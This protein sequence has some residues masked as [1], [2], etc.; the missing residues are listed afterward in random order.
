MHAVGGGANARTRSA[1][2]VG[3]HPLAAHRGVACRCWERARAR[4][5]MAMCTPATRAERNSVSPRLSNCS[6]SSAARRHSVRMRRTTQTMAMRRSA[7]CR[8][9]A[10]SSASC[11]RTVAMVMAPT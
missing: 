5:W 2:A 8:G 10:F 7:Y 3:G 4:A 6:S 9:Q 11:T 1:A